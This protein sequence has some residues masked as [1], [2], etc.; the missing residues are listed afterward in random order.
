MR[1]TTWMLAALITGL[2]AGC[3][4][5]GGGGS[6]QPKPLASTLLPVQGA[7]P[8]TNF[9]FDLGMVVGNRYYFTDRTNASVDV[10][11]TGSGAQVAQIKGTGANAF[12][13]TGA[14]NAVSGPDGINAVGNL[15]YV[16]DVNS[17]KII[18]PS[19]NTIIK[20]I[21]VGNQNVRADEGC[22]D[23]THNLYFIATPEGSPPWVTV[24]N[25]QTQMIVAQINFVDPA[26]NATAGLEECQYDTASDTF[27]INN[28]GTTANPNGELISIPG[29]SI[30]GIAAGATV[31]YTT[32]AGAVGYS[33]GNCDP[34][35]LALGPGTDIAV[36]CREGT[37][38]APLLVEIFNRNT[39]VMVTTLNAGGGDQLEYDA[40]QNRYFSA[41]SRWTP[42]GLSSGGSCVAN[43][44]AACTP[45]LI[46]IDAGTRTILSKVATGNNAHSVA[47]DPAS[48]LVFV[49]VSS[50][51][52]PAGCINCNNGSAGVLM[53]TTRY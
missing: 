51:A 32:L 47:V 26:G 1:N 50:D 38:G 53:L 23:P 6:L 36:N 19:T 20:T 5:G 25:T 41:A 4:G 14:S 35:G 49:P 13:G 28:D 39:G 43:G 2:L 11:D 45:R 22:V 7:G 30:R 29:A 52:S 40:G 34:T 42:N 16:G 46:T 18:D 8:T 10:F 24:I 21:V 27:F 48:G 9:G 44:A 31:N 17:V 12:A 33:E 37:A 15:I 3:G